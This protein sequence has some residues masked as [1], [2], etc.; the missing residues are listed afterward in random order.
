VRTP[1]DIVLLQTTVAGLTGCF[2]DYVIVV[3][4]A[5]MGV[6]KMTKEHL[7]VAIALDIPVI[8][9]VTKV[10]MCPPNVLEHTK[11]D[12]F[13]ILKSNGAKKTPFHVRNE[14]VCAGSPARPPVACARRPRLAV[15]LTLSPAPAPATTGRGDGAFEHRRRQDCPRVP[16]LGGDGRGPPAPA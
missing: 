2:P 7:G 14:Q 4:G 15:L 13:R 16:A 10:D 8:V 9:A 5:N 3:V 1:T 11:K 6:L 12:L